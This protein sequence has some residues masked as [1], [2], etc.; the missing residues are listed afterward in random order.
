MS[1]TTLLFGLPSEFQQLRHQGQD[2]NRKNYRLFTRRAGVGPIANSVAG[3]MIA[4]VAMLKG[5]TYEEACFLAR[6]RR[7]CG[8]SGYGADQ[9]RKSKGRR[10]GQA[11]RPGA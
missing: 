2:I 3:P 4:F 7:R 11:H 10:R 6:R 1:T 8:R 5:G 9:K